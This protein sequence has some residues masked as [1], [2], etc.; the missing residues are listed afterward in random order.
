MR[1][2]YKNFLLD[3]CMSEKSELV[4]KTEDLAKEIQALK[5]VN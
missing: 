2:D 3:E 4:H 5:N 1:L